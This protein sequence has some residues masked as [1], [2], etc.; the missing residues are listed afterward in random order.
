MTRTKTWHVMHGMSWRAEQ[1]HKKWCPSVPR[2]TTRQYKQ[3]AMWWSFQNKSEPTRIKEVARC[4][5]TIV[6]MSI[7]PALTP[8]NNLLNH[9]RHKL[10]SSKKK[11]VL[12]W[13]NKHRNHYQQA[14]CACRFRTKTAHT[15][16]KTNI[17][18]RTIKTSRTSAV[19]PTKTC[20]A[21]GR[22]Q[23]NKKSVP[24][25]AKKQRKDTN[26]RKR[27]DIPLSNKT[28]QTRK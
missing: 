24:A 3:R 1:K 19:M 5:H 28:A 2:R 26:N 14:S 6:K 4:A 22:E 8:T 21:Q 25:W 11:N 10:A 23:Q 20:T 7:T 18:A 15:R 13:A 17:A 27:Y 16:E 9:V 12:A